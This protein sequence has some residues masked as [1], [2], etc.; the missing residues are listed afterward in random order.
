MFRLHTFNR[1]DILPHHSTGKRLKCPQPGA[2]QTTWSF[3]LRLYINANTKPTVCKYANQTDIC[4]SRSEHCVSCTF[5]SKVFTDESR[6]KGRKTITSAD[7]GRK[8]AV[9]SR[10]PPAALTGLWE[11]EL[12]ALQMVQTLLLRES[13]ASP[14]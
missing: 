3:S 8:A 5:P 4:S 2:K 12:P 7:D 9:E 13:S 14:T 6:L 1:N 11:S 10:G